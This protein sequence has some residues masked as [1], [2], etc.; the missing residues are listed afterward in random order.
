MVYAL[1][2]IG[3]GLLGVALDL[4]NGWRDGWASV[5]GAFGAFL[6]VMGCITAAFSLK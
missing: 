1:W 4:L 5:V 6:T 3:L 2:M